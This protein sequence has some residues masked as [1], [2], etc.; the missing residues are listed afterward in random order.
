MLKLHVL[1]SEFFDE[2]RQEFVEGSSYELELEHSL[3][4]LSKWESIFEKPFLGKEQK[5]HEEVLMYI[6][7]M[8]ITKGIPDNIVSM[9]TDEQTAQ[10]NAYIE[11]KHTATW[12]T[13]FSKP[14]TSRETITSEL[15]YYWMF[16]LTIPIEC[17]DWNLNRLLT[18]IKIFQVKNQPPKKMSRSEIA[19]RNRELNERRRAQ[20]G[21]SG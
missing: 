9:L 14:T 12:F 2:E 17:E 21:T 18:L 13:D 10:I 15:I 11:A 5:T 4:S 7:C 1:E 20:L 16:S 8:I 6:K 3:S 19:A